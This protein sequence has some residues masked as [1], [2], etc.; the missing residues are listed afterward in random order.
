MPVSG[1]AIFEKG[2]LAS[3]ILKEIMAETLE[4]I[5]ADV[6]ACELCKLCRTRTVGVPGEGSPTAEV[7][8]I[9]EGAGFHE[10]PQ[11]RPF[12]CAA[13]QLLTEMLRTIGMRRDD[14][15]ITNVVRC[16]PP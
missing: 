8:L 16:R 6:R 7:M 1:P 4:Q 10:D 2:N 9:G 11:G 12:V 13:G 14:V 5:G 15:F 3:A